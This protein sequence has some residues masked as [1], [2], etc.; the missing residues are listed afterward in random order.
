MYATQIYDALTNLFRCSFHCFFLQT[1]QELEG[2]K[3]RRGALS[4]C[5]GVPYDPLFY[6][7]CSGVVTP[8][9]GSKPKCCGT[10][11]HDYASELC[12]Q[13]NIYLKNGLRPGYCG[14]L[15]FDAEFFLCCA[16]DHISPKRGTNLR[17][18]GIQG[19]DPA[20]ERCCPGYVVVTGLQ[21][22]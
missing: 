13:G 14:S 10:R 1:G 11:S 18:C 16:A 15:A 7:C 6:L 22:P 4:D 3:D 19:Y 9:T 12:C 8:K 5:S 17:C 21:C 2:A 20:I